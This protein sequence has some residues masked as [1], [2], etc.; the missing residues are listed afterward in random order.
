[1]GIQVRNR[2]GQNVRVNHFHFASPN[3]FLDW[4]TEM[5]RPTNGRSVILNSRFASPSQVENG[6][7]VLRE[8]DTSNLPAAQ[9]LIDRFNEDISSLR[10]VWQPSIAGFFPNV[11]AFLMGEPES[12]WR[13]DTEDSDTAPIRVWVGLGSSG[14]ITS[15]QLIKRGAA[16]SAFALA[17]SER[18]PVFITPYWDLGHRLNDRGTLISFDLQASPVVL[19][20]VI[21][22]LTNPDFGR[23]L[24]LHAAF[25][26]DPST[27]A[28][29]PWFPGA[30]DEKWMRGCLGCEDADIWL[31]GVMSGDKTITDPV[32]WIKQEIAKHIG[33][34]E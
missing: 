19:S 2:S 29:G 9:K 12:M 21:A 13:V 4:V 33:E 27:P 31:P 14:A 16:L 34:Q 18:R 25:L 17:L 22:A 28:S 1:M 26:V 32:A 11:P 10:R 6:K 3:R 8:G 15:D 30:L 7:R 23:Y 24:A 20:E 5:E